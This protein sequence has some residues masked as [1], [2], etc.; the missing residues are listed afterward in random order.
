M[1]AFGICKDWVIVL[2]PESRR[3]D[4]ANGGWYDL[5]LARTARHLV[6]CR[7]EVDAACQ[8]GLAEG[9]DL[10]FFAQTPSAYCKHVD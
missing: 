9:Q 5:V 6:E 7:L 8:P 3:S 4:L 1:L 10:S 2:F